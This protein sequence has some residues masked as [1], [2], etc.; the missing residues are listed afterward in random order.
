M[1]Y[2]SVLFLILYAA[3]SFPVRA[4]TG[5]ILPY[6]EKIEKI[7]SLDMELHVSVFPLHKGK[8]IPKSSHCF[9][10]FQQQV[11]EIL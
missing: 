6:H 4:H 2:I 10:F 3:G 9:I 5:A 1:Q 8:G 7:S 11:S